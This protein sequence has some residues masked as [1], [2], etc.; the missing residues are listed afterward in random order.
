M[1]KKRTWKVVLSILLGF[2]VLVAGSLALFALFDFPGL[3][4]QFG[5][6]HQ[7]DMGILQL[8]MTYNL[9]LSASIC[10]WAVV[11]L[12]RD[13]LAGVQTGTTVG[14]LI[15]L[16]SMIVF[17]QFNRIDILL[18]DGVRALLMVVSGALAYREHQRH[19]STVK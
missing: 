9:A 3:L 4:E 18:F 19:H 14:L 17:I 7:P 13:Q 2:Q 11:W 15:F 6:K 5:L 16:T 8:I 1:K 12:R 10:A